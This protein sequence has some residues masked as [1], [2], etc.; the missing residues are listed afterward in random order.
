M[1]ENALEKPA[2]GKA[3]VPKSVLVDKAMAQ[4]ET[5]VGGRDGLSAALA[6]VPAAADVDRLLGL[7]ADPEYARKGLPELCRAAGIP[8]SQVWTLWRSGEVARASALATRSIGKHLPNVVEDVMKRAAPY[9]D[10]CDVCGG[11]GQTTPDPT[12]AAPNPTPETCERCCGGGKL[13]YDPE[14][15]RQVV[16]LKISGLLKDGGGALVFNQNLAVQNN[17]NAS[18]DAGA[19]EKLSE[20]T[21]QILYG[22]AAPRDAQTEYVDGE[23]VTGGAP[24]GSPS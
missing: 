9:E 12:P 22:D 15:D 11:L 5:A 8:L 2:G 1:A 23:E 4:L 14:L 19:L 6:F 21:D 7:L 20:A 18:G 3:L 24:E 10:V 17:L 13:R 16:A